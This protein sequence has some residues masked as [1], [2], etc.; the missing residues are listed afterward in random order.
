M[1]GGGSR[2]NGPCI[3]VTGFELLSSIMIWPG[4]RTVLLVEEDRRSG[5][6]YLG[7][8]GRTERRREKVG[9]RGVG[10]EVVGRGLELGEGLESKKQV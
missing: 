2:G 3:P 1:W 9:K 6:D 10:A 4:C 7:S 8:G 5:A